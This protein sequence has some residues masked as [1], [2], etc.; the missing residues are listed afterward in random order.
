MQENY[1]NIFCTFLGQSFSE[2][3]ISA[4][5]VL[6]LVK[7]FYNVC[8]NVQSREGLINFLNQH[9]GKY[10]FLSKLVF[11]LQNPKSIF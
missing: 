11:K 2:K 1:I 7:A 9:I 4:E 8:D 10:Q 6:E 5:G 3:H